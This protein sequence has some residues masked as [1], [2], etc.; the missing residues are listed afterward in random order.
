MKKIIS[1]LLAVILSAA[2][3]TVTADAA[4]WTRT[5]YGYAYYYENGTAAKSGWLKLGDNTY[6]IQPNGIRKTGWLKSKQGAKYYF[7]QNGVMAKN[8]VVRFADGSEYYFMS[9]GK[10]AS[11]YCLK[12]GRYLYHYGY[13]GKLTDVEAIDFG[14]TLEK[15]TDVIDDSYYGEGFDTD[16]VYGYSTMIIGLPADSEYCVFTHNSS[17]YYDH[18]YEFTEGKLTAYGYMFKEENVAP[19]TVIN[20][21]TK[22]FDEAP[23]F[24]YEKSEACYWDFGWYYL[25]L[26]H[27]EADRYCAVYST[28]KPYIADDII[29]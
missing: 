1:A 2:A 29:M 7:D 6:Y 22:Q 27:Y 21:F 10:M 26:F 19:E 3:A 18:L 16:E 11:E 9:D 25:S 5:K 15:F 14:M 20:Y 28:N 12:T 23:E 8:K 24:V 13:D 17:K 4:G